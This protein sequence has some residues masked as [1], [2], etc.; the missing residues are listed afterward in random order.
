MPAVFRRK[1]EEKIDAFPPDRYM[2]PP[3]DEAW[4]SAE[5]T[6]CTSTELAVA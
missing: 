4:F 5:D 6:A 2:K 1:V 3:P